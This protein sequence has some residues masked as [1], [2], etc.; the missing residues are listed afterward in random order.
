MS[1]SSAVKRL[2]QD[3]KY[4]E[5]N[6]VVGASG[7][8]RDDNIFVWHL[9]F[10][11]ELTV[12]GRKHQVPMHA[13][14]EAPQ[15]YP[16]NPPNVGFCVDFHYTM[17]ASYINKNEGPMKGT[18][19]LC[20]NLLGNF[21]HVHTEWKAVEGEGWGPSMSVETVLIQLQTLL[22][23]LDN[24][25]SG[26]EKSKLLSASQKFTATFNGKTHSFNSPYPTLPTQA[27]VLKAQELKKMQ[28]SKRNAEKRV[29]SVVSEELKNEMEIFLKELKGGKTQRNDFFSILSQMMNEMMESPIEEKDMEVELDIRGYF[30]NTSY[31]ED[32]LGYGVIH[33]KKIFKS[34]G[35]L[36]SLGSFNSGCRLSTRKIAFTEWIPAFINKKH[37]GHKN[38]ASTVK[39]RLQGLCSKL[40]QRFYKPHYVLDILPN[41]INSMIVEIMKGDKSASISYFEALCSFWRTLRWFLKESPEADKLRA[42]AIDRMKNFVKS[43]EGRHKDK[44]PDI[45]QFLALYTTLTDCAPREQIIDAYLRESFVRSVMWWNCRPDASEVFEATRVG[46][47]LF[48]FQLT[49]IRHLVGSNPDE[50]TKLMDSSGGRVPERLDA[51]QKAWKNTKCESF[52]DYF[53]LTTASKKYTE[54]CLNNTGGWL[55]YLQQQAENKGKR[56]VK[57][58]YNNNRSNNR[59]SGGYGNRDAGGNQRRNYYGNREY[60][61]G[62]R[63]RNQNYV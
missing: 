35:E 50:T 58:K 36:L 59:R 40:D 14:L 49:V 10:A 41:L 2:A 52:A 37:I 17:G 24:N 31:T 39:S 7:V 11:I 54:Q 21:A 48:L 51:L 62:R 57:K 33:E 19:V 29:Y 4:L 16:M 53:H 22:L 15:D 26:A 1:R 8:P 27:D 56:Y 30:L 47:E 6:P 63:R 45:G 18:K 61:N 20:L 28:K 44:V 43:E 55:R 46:R 13:I 38:W 42:Q 12:S 23:D 5:E 32:I 3:F 9:N 60:G 34:P 25:M